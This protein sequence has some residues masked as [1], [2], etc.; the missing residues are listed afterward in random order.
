[1]AKLVCQAGPTAGHEYPL[2]KDKCLFGRQRSCE[3]QILDSMA[4][5]EHF[6]IRRDGGLFTIMDLESRNGTLVNGRRVTEAQLEFGDKIK[7]GEVVYVFVK[8]QG[9][10]E[11]KD[12][13]SSRYQIMEK[14][15]QG[16]MGIVYKANQR[17]M[18]RLVA[19]KVLSPKFA[20]RPR[21]VEQFIR[22][23][24]AAGQLGHP[25]IIQVHDVGSEHEV[26]FFAMEY[27]DGVTCMQLLRTHGPLSATAALEIAR[28]VT[29]ALEY[30]HSRHII[31]RDVKPDNIMIGTNN[32]VKL[33]DLGISKTFEE[34]EAEG[35]PKRIVGTPHYM[36]PEAIMGK[37][38][39]HRVDLYSLG[40]TLYHLLA[41]S[42]PF[43]GATATDI[44]KAHAM[45][46][47]RPLTEIN[48]DLSPRVASL[49]STLMAKDPEARPSSASEVLSIIQDIQ[50]KHTDHMGAS[51]DTA[52]LQRLAKNTQETVAVGNPEKHVPVATEGKS[53]AAEPPQ[54]AEPPHDKPTG[55]VHPTRHTA[56]TR[57]RS[58]VE[59][60]RMG[61]YIVIVLTIAFIGVLIWKTP[62]NQGNVPEK[63][64]AALPTD[65]VAH[66]DPVKNLNGPQVKRTDP[67]EHPA[68]K[69]LLQI[70]AR[71]AEPLDA[72][73]LGE[74]QQKLQNLTNLDEVTTA[75]RDALTKNIEDRLK[76]L[77]TDALAA[78]VEALRGKI[79]E[80]LRAE[81]F[82][83][84]TE[85]LDKAINANPKL[86]TPSIA[87]LKKSLPSKMKDAR[88]LKEREL[89]GL[90]K[91][92]KTTR[93][94]AFAKSLPADAAFDPVREKVAGLRKQI[95][96]LA[97]KEDA[98]SYAAF[99]TAF[100]A[101]N[102]DRLPELAKEVT[103]AKKTTAESRLAIATTTLTAIN[104]LAKA[105]NGA[106]Q[107]KKWPGKIAGID[108]PVV[109][110]LQASGVTLQLP[111]G[112][113]MQVAWKEIDGNE[114]SFLAQMI[115]GIEARDLHSKIV[116]MQKLTK[117]QTQ[118]EPPKTGEK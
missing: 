58:A 99:E 41:G 104:Q 87:G 86:E 66:T 35:A 44:L 114:L 69:T 56:G 59:T 112:G 84:A 40:A 11:V 115:L 63:D 7:V 55:Q 42:T 94:D 38:I 20:A 4:S 14:I 113:S 32:V 85:M 21:F 24:R 48:L 33:A 67:V 31:H 72:A 91:D 92:T 51:A 111:E 71:L 70:A 60:I 18:D 90:V 100:Q 8:E 53:A 97:S 103:G 82:T 98:E 36:A 95:S 101:W 34:A 102:F 27:V 13:L 23:A 52:L 105:Y 81:R 108:H 89:A 50:G 12:L 65:P 88:D 39:D 117:P 109:Q 30:A 116:A 75:K 10:L 28:Q 5:R 19:L 107:R 37:Q 3:V 2:E 110:S 93:L 43:T 22:E 78:E 61:L 77:Q 96:E 46:P 57:P 1:M 106:S 68:H 74:L 29:K 9:D 62:K 79:D 49:I 15:G 6:L 83:A 47:L 73:A 16:G 64:P 76:L 45:A 118:P 17:S 26:H 25:N 80:L 54:A